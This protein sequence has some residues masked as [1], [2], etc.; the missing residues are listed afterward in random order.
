MDRRG[1]KDTVVPT[2]PTR[3]PGLCPHLSQALL[4]LSLLG[5]TSLA[6]QSAARDRLASVLTKPRCG[7]SNTLTHASTPSGTKQARE[8]SGGLTEARRK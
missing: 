3:E 7:R 4:E 8:W 2:L 1:D 5:L 6:T